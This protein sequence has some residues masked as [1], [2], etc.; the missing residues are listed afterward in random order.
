MNFE[1]NNVNT[2]LELPNPNRFESAFLAIGA[3]AALVGGIATIIHSREFF[4]SGEG[5]MALIMVA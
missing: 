3:A 2:F 5:G 1:S 4:R